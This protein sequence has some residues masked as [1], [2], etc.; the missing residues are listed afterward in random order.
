MRKIWFYRKADARRLS[1]AFLKQSHYFDHVRRMPGFAPRITFG[2]NALDPTDRLG[3]AREEEISPRWE[4]TRHDLF[5]LGGAGWLYLAESGL[6]GL[7]I[8]RIS[9][10]QGLGN[11]R[12]D[13]K[14]YPFL[15][16]KAIWI[17]VSQEV[18]DAILATGRLRGPVFTFPNGIDLSPVEG[19]EAAYRVK[20]RP[21]TIAGYKR[22][23]LARGLS[24]RLDGEGIAHLSLTDFCDRGAFLDRLAESRVAVCLP[25]EQ[26][27]FYLV[28]LEAMAAGC[29][30]VTVD[31]I[32]NRGFCRHEENCLIAEPGIGSLFR[33]AQRAL[34]MPTPE[35]EAL[36]RRA[37]YTV[38]AHS[39]EGERARFHA[40]LA[41]VDRLWRNG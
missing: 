12:E 29:V 38:K 9:L 15:A 32:G 16:N 2:G 28:A 11:A 26:E 37:R 10:I 3:A 40:L 41:D 36:R 13:S 20:R 7:P 14:V 30:V 25:R 27:G 8:P 1:G 33:A 4:P 21:L 19:S 23:D 5:F 6:G 18:A 24:Q 22:P 17:C 35:R 31:C 34:D 39:L